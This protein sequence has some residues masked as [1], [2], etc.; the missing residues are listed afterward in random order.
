MREHASGDP[1]DVSGARDVGRRVSPNA[2]AHRHA[3]SPRGVVLGE[4]IDAQLCRSVHD[5][6]LDAVADLGSSFEAASHHV[7]ETLS[8]ADGSL[9]GAEPGQLVLVIVLPGGAGRGDGRHLLELLANVGEGRLVTSGLDCEP[10]EPVFDLP[11]MHGS[12][13]CGESARPRT[14]V[15][16]WRRRPTGRK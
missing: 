14:S 6:Q 12:S 7:L 11:S 16:A 9:N 13:S 3:T 2:R 8:G 5:P 10:V 4:H 1:N 15:H